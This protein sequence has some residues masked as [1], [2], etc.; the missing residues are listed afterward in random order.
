M[1]ATWPLVLQQFLNEASFSYSF[2]STKIESDTDTG[3]PKIRKRYTKA[4]NELQ[5]SIKLR[6]DQVTN[7]FVSFENFYKTTLN[8]GTTTFNFEHPLRLVQSEF[9]F[10]GDPALRPMGGQYFELSFTWIEV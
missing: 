1:P 7:E 9:R 10:K 3:E 5:G 8:G 6:V 4:I 2:G